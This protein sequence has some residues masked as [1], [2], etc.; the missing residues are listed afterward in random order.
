MINFCFLR[1]G[2]RRYCEI[3]RIEL[4]FFQDMSTILLA[5]VNIVELRQLG[6]IKRGLPSL[7]KYD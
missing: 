7:A 4:V 6:S 1:G 2:A 3:D 5:I